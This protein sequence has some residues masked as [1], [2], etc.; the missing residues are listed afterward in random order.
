MTREV[1]MKLALL[2]DKPG[3]YIMRS[4]GEII[5]VGKAK[6]LKNRVRQYFHTP[7]K[8]TPKVRAMVE[9]VDDFDTVIVDTDLEAFTLECNLIKLHM[10]RYN[11]V[12][13]DDKHYPYIRLDMREDYPACELV[14]SQKRDGAKYFGPYHGSLAVREVLDT[15]RML[16]PIRSCRGKIAPGRTRRACMY[17]QTGQCPAPCMGYITPQDYRAQVK[18]VADF[19]SGRYDGV[20]DE[21]RA[22][23]KES[24]DS[25]NYEKAAVYRDRIRAVEQVMQKQQAIST[26]EKDYDV[27][28]CAQAGADKQVQVLTSR[29]GRLIDSRSFVLE[30]EL[31]DDIPECETRF[32]TQY[33]SPEAL[34]PGEILLDRMPA[35][36]E[37]TEGYL[38]ELAGRKVHIRVPQRGD[39]AKLVRMAV[40]NLEDAAQK[41]RRKLAEKEART[42][43]ATKELGEALGLPFVPHR[44]EGYDISNTMGAQSV[45]SMVVSVDGVAAKKEY[46]RFRIRTVE[47]A[48]DFASIHEVLLRRLTHGLKEKREIEE[49]KLDRAKASFAELPDLILVDGGWGQ[50]QEGMRAMRESGLDIPMFGLAKRIDEIVLPD[51]SGSLLLDRRSPAL[52]LIERLRDESHRFAITHH[53]ALRAKHSMASVLEGTRGIGAARRRAILAYFGSVEKLTQ[54]DAEEI[55]KVPRLPRDAA[56]RVYAALHGT[57][58]TEGRNMFSLAI[59]GPAGAGKSTVAR[60]V[61]EQKGVMYMDTGAMYRTVG[62]AVLR[63]GKDPASEE[64]TLGVLAGSS[65]ALRYDG[66]QRV[67]LNGEDVTDEIRTPECSRAASLVSRYAEVRRSMV[68]LQRETAKGQSVVMDGRDIGT[69]V[70][71][72]ATL[73]IYLTASAQERARRRLLELT[74]KEPGVTFEKVLE[75]IRMRDEQDM[76]REVSPLRQAEDAVVVDTSDM[77]AQQAASHILALLE[78]RI[79]L[80]EGK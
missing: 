51:G 17:Y 73:K 63:Q 24:A 45:A 50:L 10:P 19:L 79:A 35:D 32:L 72:D 75:E 80:R 22:R 15:V 37:E 64:D 1:E 38:S 25:Y 13:K 78:K 56:L 34:P 66:G 52:H 77:T 71:P 58:A 7:E 53:R 4:A 9:K 8:H 12:L 40:K 65:I 30:G 44:I 60:L 57:T 18:H 41:R 59:D 11:I 54:A 5:Y 6:N 67:T 27:V 21:L 42:L 47:G 62:L 36:R 49:G 3:C 31:D 68:A 43:Q 70:L 29:G 26:R 46:R 76:N 23:M 48:N 39:G 74:A 16:F 14:R 28:A 33:Y 55:A 61:A 69:D 2:P 20:L